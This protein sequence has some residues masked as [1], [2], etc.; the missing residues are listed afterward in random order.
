MRI[1]LYTTKVT[2]NIDIFFDFPLRHYN[3]VAGSILNPPNSIAMKKLFLSMALFVCAILQV[4]ALTYTVTVPTGTNECFITGEMNDWT[5]QPMIK[6]DDTHF[7]IELP[8]ALDTQKYKYC[9]GPSWGY[10]EKANGG[11]DVGNRTYSPKDEVKV[12]AAVFDRN[13]PDFQL[14][15]NVTVPK[16]TNCCYIFGG[17]DGWKDAKEM[18]KVDDAHFKVTLLSN[19]QLRYNYAAGPGYG[20]M[21]WN[22]AR[23]RKPID[24]HYAE[25]DT[26][27][28]WAAIY[29]KAHP[30]A[31]I[32]YTVTVP[33]GTKSCFIAGG[34]DGWEK[35]TEM[36]KVDATTFAVTFKSN[37]ALKY[38]YLMGADWKLM[39]LTA[40]G[41]EPNVRSYTTKDVIVKWNMLKQPN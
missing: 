8:S 33:E 7:T 36:K 2:L 26:V 13:I 12:W 32:T 34:W 17:W 38:V 22:P 20:Y 23:Q 28:N 21:E 6:V 11:W 5:Q 15:Y 24:R 41:K 14:T 35:F 1:K 27:S 3:F 19:K 4:N 39:E 18:T 40:N 30:D 37:T 16:G 9:S 29:D 25:S 31:K 10:V